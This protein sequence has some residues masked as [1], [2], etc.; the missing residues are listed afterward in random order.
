G[1]VRVLLDGLGAPL[2][3]TGNNVA[4]SLR[5]FLIGIA[6]ADAQAEDTLQHASPLLSFRERRAGEPVIGTIRLRFWTAVSLGTWRLCV[7]ETRGHT[8]RC[9]S[10]AR[11]RLH[12]LY[13]RWSNFRN[14]SPY[15]FTVA[16]HDLRSLFV[17]YTCPR[18]VALISVQSGS[19]S[20]I[21]PMDLIGPTPP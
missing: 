13:Q 10:P 6:F 18:P 1:H 9:L 19:A 15:N 17:F 3:V 14:R 4:V 8:N 12:Y 2:D 7:F 5:P 16:P 21:F 20:N 11:L